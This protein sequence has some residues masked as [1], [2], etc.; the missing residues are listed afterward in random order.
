MLYDMPFSKILLLFMFFSVGTHVKA[1]GISIGIGKG[2]EDITAYRISGFQDWQKNLNISSNWLLKGFWEISLSNWNSNNSVH[3]D[4]HTIT[5]F[6]L[7]PVFVIQNTS[8]SFLPYV[9]AGIGGAWLSDTE[10]GRKELSTHFQFEDRIGVGFHLGR[11]HAFNLNFSAF[12]F[13][14]GS[15]KQPNEGVNL[16]L[17]TLTHPL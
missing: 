4:N 14:N 16:L 13:S 7:S 12:H 6:A 8:L 17:L 5:L 2:D 9:Q 1:S 11:E 3:H 15:I 10:I